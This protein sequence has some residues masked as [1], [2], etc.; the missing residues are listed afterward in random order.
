MSIISDDFT[1]RY[2][3]VNEKAMIV[4]ENKIQ[5]TA[6]SNKPRTTDDEKGVA[7][8]WLPDSL[9]LSRNASSVT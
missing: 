8:T 2:V 5:E 7:Q 3:T 9:S 6:I 1:L 4:G